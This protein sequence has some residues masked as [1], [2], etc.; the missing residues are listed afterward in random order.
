[1]VNTSTYFSVGDLVVWIIR[2]D[3]S[4]LHPVFLQTTPPKEEKEETKEN[5]TETKRTGRKRLRPLEQGK[6]NSNILLITVERQ[7][8]YVSNYFITL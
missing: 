2:Y 7:C 3:R 8:L 4:N 1:V 6:V 5:K